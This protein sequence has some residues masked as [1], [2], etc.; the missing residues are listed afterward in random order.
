MGFWG[1]FRRKPTQPPG[2]AGD[3][4]DQPRCH[5]YTLAH[6]ALRTIAADPLA[7]LAILASPDAQPFLARVLPSV[8]KHCS[9][10]EPQPD[11]GIDDVTVHRVRV[12]RYPCAVIG[13]PS[14]RATTEAYFTAAVLLADPEEAVQGFADAAR[15]EMRYF[16]LEKGFLFAGP[17]C[18]VLCE[19]TTEGSHVNH[20]D[21]PAPELEAFVQAMGELLARDSRPTGGE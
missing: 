8:S 1:L 18:T 3:D 19:W 16:T 6:C 15:L 4:L 17:P 5:H 10:T 7:Y 14:P 9:D 12:G 20:G 2:R 11:F 13:L 21:G